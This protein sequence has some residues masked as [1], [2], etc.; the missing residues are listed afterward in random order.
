[1]AAVDYLVESGWFKEIKSSDV[2]ATQY[3]V[4]VLTERNNQ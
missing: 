2:A 4:F 3:R 1:M